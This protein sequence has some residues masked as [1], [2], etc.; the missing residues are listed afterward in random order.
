MLTRA[1]SVVGTVDDEEPA[2]VKHI[3]KLLALIAKVRS[4][5]AQRDGKEPAEPP[6]PAS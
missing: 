5:A 6:A 2:W 1:A 4:L 3:R